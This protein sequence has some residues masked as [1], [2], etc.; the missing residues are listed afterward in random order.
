[1]VKKANY[2]AYDINYHLVV[3]LK[4]R[5]KIL[6]K[7][8]YIQHL[9]CLVNEIAERYEFE[10]GNINQDELIILGGQCPL[11]IHLMFIATVKLE[12]GYIKHDIFNNLI[13]NI[14]KV[15]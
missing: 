5:K 2:C 13:K 8:E 14:Y 12:H 4:F 3:V 11:T 6:V 10:M 15:N 1:M 9:C 7:Q